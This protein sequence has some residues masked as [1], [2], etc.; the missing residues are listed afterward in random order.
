MQQHH[1]DD[2]QQGKGG[3]DGGRIR[4][5]H[6]RVADHR[7]E[8]AATSAPISREGRKGRCSG[9]RKGY[10]SE[11]V[12]TLAVGRHGEQHRGV[13]PDAH[14]ADV[15]ESQDAG[16]AHV[17]LQPQHQDQA[18]EHDGDDADQQGDAQQLGEERQTARYP[19]PG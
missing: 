12:S 15:G 13:G 5:A 4:Q 11:L 1:V 2:D 16:I 9:I 8:Q 6:E 10:R 3:D 14:E 18:D 19:P 17:E 7:G